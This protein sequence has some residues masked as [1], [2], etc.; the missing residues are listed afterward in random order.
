MMKKIL[1]YSALLMGT[2]FAESQAPT[3]PKDYWPQKE[4]T[5]TFDKA[6]R[7]RGYQVYK[8]V[9]SSCHS[10]RLLTFRKLGDLGFKPDE[11]KALAAQYETATIDDEGKIVTRKALPSDTL[12]LPYLNNTLYN[13]KAYEK[14]ARAANNGALPPDLSLII[15]ARANGENYV[16]AL[17]TGY[18]NPPADMKINE[19]MYYNEYFPGHQIAM[20]PPLT[21][22]QVT[23][24]DG[25]EASVEQMAKDVVTFLSWVSEPEL[26]ERK[27]MGFNVMFY[28]VIM[29][30]VF[31]LAK[32]K[33]WADVK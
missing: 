7:Q 12:P 9:C 6:A 18:K 13:K 11:I 30:A 28:L 33:I 17:L 20:A 10:M 24:A 3:P 16:K 14:A 5:G 25:T 23:Y 21:A 22:G 4:I 29:T 15:K 2:A 27:R 32:R 31:Y 1:T 19:G 26:E 8:E